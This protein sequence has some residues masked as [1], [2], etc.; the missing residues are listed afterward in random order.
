MTYVVT[1]NCINAGTD[2]VEVCPV[3]SSSALG[4]RRALRRSFASGQHYGQRFCSICRCQD[5][6]G[7]RVG[8]L[9]RSY[10]DYFPIF[11]SAIPVIE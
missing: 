4:Q 5:T 3:N 9:S 10:G 7:L 2:C 11:A 8:A 1:E 6:L